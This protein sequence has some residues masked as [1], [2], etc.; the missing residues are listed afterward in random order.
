VFFDLGGG[1]SLNL[2][3][4]CVNAIFGM[5]LSQYKLEDITGFLSIKS[6][7]HLTDSTCCGTRNSGDVANRVTIGVNSGGGYQLKKEHGHV[8]VW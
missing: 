8:K 4:G 5:I 1:V 3:P 7:P 2:M 6:R